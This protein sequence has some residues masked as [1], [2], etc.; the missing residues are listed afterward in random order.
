MSAVSERLRLAVAARA[1]DRCEYCR[2]P[3]QWQVARF[4]IDHVHP[5]TLGGE[6]SLENLAYACPSCNAF[7][8]A[9][10]TG[11]DPVSGVEHPL[12][13]PRTDLWSDHFAWSGGNGEI[14]IGKTAK[15]RA[16]IERLNMNSLEMVAIRSALIRL[17]VN[18]AAVE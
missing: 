2:L 7:K 12:F 5:R 8:W 14:L 17:G 15:G 16:T 6:T 3:A 9:H 18:F 1:N 4:P 11:I 10:I 13:N